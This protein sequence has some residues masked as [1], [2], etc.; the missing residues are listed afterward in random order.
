[1]LFHMCAHT[2]GWPFPKGGSQSISDALAAKLRALG[3]KVECGRPVRSLREVPPS[4]VVLFDVTPRQLV[5][6]AGDELPAGYRR[7]LARFKY[8]PGTF[9]IDYALDGPIPWK[10]SDATRAGNVHLGGTYEEIAASED[11]VT[12]GRIPERPWVIVAQQSLFDETR[13][14]A[15]KHT[16][17]TYCHVPS[18]STVDMTDAIEDQIERFAPGF[19]DLVLARS[20]RGP[21]DLE[22][23]NENY[24]GGD[25]AGGLSSLRQLF[26]RPVVRLDPYSTPNPRLFLCSSSTPPGAGVHGMCGYFAARSALKRLS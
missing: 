9:K 26:T 15:G 18:S 23:Y 8:G 21:A 2:N 1:M 20:V 10:A 3:G 5:A 17:W 12:K 4:R 25:I 13:A 22:R 11:T 6:I 7:R 14:P 24:V 19:R 16:A